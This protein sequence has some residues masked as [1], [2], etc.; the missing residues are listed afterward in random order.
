MRIE[1]TVSVEVERV[2]GKFAPKDDIEAAVIEA[3]EGANPDTISG[4]GA[5][6]DSE[7]QVTD[8]VVE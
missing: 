2:Q 3:I 6:G 1:V 5:D 8:W 4:V 7:Y